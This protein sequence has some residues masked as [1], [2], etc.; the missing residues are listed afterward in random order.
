MLKAVQKFIVSALGLATTPLSGSDETIV[1]QSGIEKR[2]TVDNFTSGRAVPLGNSSTV[3]TSSVFPFISSN[4]VKV[5]NDGNSATRVLVGNQDTGASAVSG[6]DFESAG[7][8]WQI[9]VPPDVITFANPLIVKFNNVE[10]L[11]FKTSG[12]FCPI[13]GAGV[14]FAE[15]PTIRAG[16]G[17]PE[18]VVTASVGSLFLRANGGA[19]TTL[20]VKESGSGNTGWVAK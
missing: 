16:N 5:G 8:G 18:N 20:Y 19:N 13:S 7:G 17:D 15:G 2:V 3:G 6:I 4:G 12:S 14:D 11:R 1:S 9:D 10:K